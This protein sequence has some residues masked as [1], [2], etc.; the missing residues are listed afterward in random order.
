MEQGLWR[1]APALLHH[2]SSS[3]TVLILPRLSGLMDTLDI[4][5]MFI[6]IEGRTL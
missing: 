4:S 1:G 6:G 3:I 2:V 5:W